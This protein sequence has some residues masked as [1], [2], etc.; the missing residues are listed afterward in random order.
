[1]AMET[2]YTAHIDLDYDALRPGMLA[3]K[4]KSLRSGM[5]MIG[6][7]LLVGLGCH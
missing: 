1:M 4:N 3:M 7:A 2:D 6:A 5:P